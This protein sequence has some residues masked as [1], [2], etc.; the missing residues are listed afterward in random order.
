LCDE[1]DLTL[2]PEDHG[3]NQW[4]NSVSPDQDDPAAAALE[5]YELAT[6]FGIEF[7]GFVHDIVSG[8]HGGAKAFFGPN[9][10]FMKKAEDSMLRKL[11]SM[12]GKVEDGRN[13]AEFMGDSLRGSITGTTKEDILNIIRVF[14]EKALARQWEVRWSNKWSEAKPYPSGYVGIHAKLHL[15]DPETHKTLLAELQIHFD[16]ILDGT[17]DEFKNC[18]KEY[19]HKIY[20]ATRILDRQNE[21]KKKAIYHRN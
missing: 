20:E 17:D 13:P 15:K 21:N 4:A 19:S 1:L 11:R 16:K 8:A 18:P 2:P 12:A 6:S 5:L 7:E 3:S 10:Q 14:K 9:N